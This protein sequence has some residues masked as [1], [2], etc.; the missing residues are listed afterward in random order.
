MIAASPPMEFVERL[1]AR[2]ARRLRRIVFPETADLRV[3][4]AIEVL[5]RNRIV[6]PV[7]VLAL[8]V[9][10]VDPHDRDVRERTVADIVAARRHK[11]M[12]E[13]SAMEH[14]SNPLFV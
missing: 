14:A 4:D 8:G 12:T 2:A 7:A 13:D 11:G 10:I 1:R 6:E 3:R 9:D 5:A